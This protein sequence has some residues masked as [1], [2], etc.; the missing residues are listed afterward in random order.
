MN[1]V[2][3]SFKIKTD[4]RISS[5]LSGRKFRSDKDFL[6]T[7]EDFLFWQIIKESDK[8]DYV[9]KEEVFSALDKKNGLI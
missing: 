3:T 9:S 1:F 4:S 6:E 7:L 8:W 5:L 2:E